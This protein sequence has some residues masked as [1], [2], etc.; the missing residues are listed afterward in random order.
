[1]LDLEIADRIEENKFNMN[2][3]DKQLKKLEKFH[4]HDL[5]E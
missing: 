5:E 3:I 1:M 4:A 2:K